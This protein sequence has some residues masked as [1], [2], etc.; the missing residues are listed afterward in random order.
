MTFLK[1]Q[2]F[3]PYHKG[4]LL[5]QVMKNILLQV[6]NIVRW[7]LEPQK[8]SDKIE[9]GRRLNKGKD[10]KSFIISALII[11]EICQDF[12]VGLHL[13]QKCP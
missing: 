7:K 8:E 11:K 2:F 9:A 1:I 13:V 12:I 6:R 10:V 5:F 4:Q 3:F